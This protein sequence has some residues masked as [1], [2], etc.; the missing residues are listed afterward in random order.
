MGSVYAAQDLRFSRWIA[1]KLMLPELMESAEFAGRFMREAQAASSLA[2]R[3]VARVFEVGRLPEG[4]PYMVMELL[5]GHDLDRVVR[6]RGPLPVAEAVEYLIETCDAIA[7]A[8]RNGIVHRDL[9]P[10]NLY[11]AEQQGARP[12]VKVLDF[13][14]SKSTKLDA[15]SRPGDG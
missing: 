6:K 11:L 9:K 10:S 3:H 7:E 12:I 5:Q 2:S 14:I 15:G 8:H 4:A 1:L 13:G